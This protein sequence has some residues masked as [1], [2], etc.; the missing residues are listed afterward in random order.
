M[1]NIIVPFRL[2]NTWLGLELKA[3][4]K[5]DSCGKISTI[6]T[7][8]TIEVPLA[9]LM[10]KNGKIFPIWS[11]FNLVG[12]KTSDVNKCLLHIEIEVDGKTIMIPVDE[13]LPVTQKGTGWIPIVKY[14]LQIFRSLDKKAPQ[15]IDD[16]EEIK[17]DH[18]FQDE[19]PGSYFNLE[20]L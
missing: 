13:I 3:V 14:G 16:V 18:P 8:P 7:I 2:N 6:P 10:Q 20:E 19:T 5:V 15:Y 1:N 17:M 4:K 12:G 11:L 9:G